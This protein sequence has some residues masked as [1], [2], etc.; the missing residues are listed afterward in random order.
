MSR[1]GSTTRGLATGGAGA[2][3][4]ASSS[5]EVMT[6]PVRRGPL[7]FSLYKPSILRRPCLPL[8]PTKRQ[9]FSVFRSRQDGPHGNYQRDWLSGVQEEDQGVGRAG[10]QEGALQGLRPRLP[11]PGN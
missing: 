11:D 9:I 2:S 3:C 10:R 4:G 6:A 8:Y 5:T 1:R 7:F